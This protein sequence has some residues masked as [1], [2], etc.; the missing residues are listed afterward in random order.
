VSRVHLFSQIV[1]CGNTAMVPPWSYS[2]MSVLGRQVLAVRIMSQ[3]GLSPSASWLPVS[4]PGK[5][6]E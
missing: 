3:Y 2:N 6:V 5:S 4:V 1:V